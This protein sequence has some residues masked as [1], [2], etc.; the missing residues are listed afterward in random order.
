VFYLGS[1]S[2]TAPLAIHP[3]SPLLV[4]GVVGPALG[5]LLDRWRLLSTDRPFATL[6]RVI[7]TLL[8]GGAVAGTLLR[9]VSDEQWWRTSSWE[10]EG[11]V[12][13]L[14]FTPSCLLIMRASARAGRA[15]LGSLNDPPAN[16]I[17]GSARSR[18]SSP[19]SRWLR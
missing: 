16:A 9:F 11:A 6:P 5:L 8:V 17:G 10:L 12:Y 4:G 1:I 13:A 19:R 18:W 7:P 2:N 14:L 3:A 15:R